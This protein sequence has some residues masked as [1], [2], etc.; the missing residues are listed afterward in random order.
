ML[1]GG[2][3]AVGPLP[4]SYNG[5]V[6]GS[7]VTASIN[8]KSAP[9]QVEASE[10]ALG[11]IR[12]TTCPG[13]ALE[14]DERRRRIAALKVAIA[15]ELTGA[16]TTLINALK[17]VSG[18]PEEGTVSFKELT[19]EQAQLDEIA[20]AAQRMSCPAETQAAAPQ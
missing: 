14:R 20:V 13:L 19:I 1:L 4:S 2:C 15:N 16:P 18:K 3:G 11:E 12:S 17:R 5:P 8:K 10:T 9:Q 7:I 6:T